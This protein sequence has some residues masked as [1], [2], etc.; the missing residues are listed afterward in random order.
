[1]HPYLVGKD[2]QVKPRQTLTK[3]ALKV[4][5]KRHTT[6]DELSQPLSKA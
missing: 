3:I 4:L 6:T 1:M 2:E 5:K